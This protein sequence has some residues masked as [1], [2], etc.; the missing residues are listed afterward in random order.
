MVSISGGSKRVKGRA[1]IFFGRLG[2]CKRKSNKIFRCTRLPLWQ[3]RKILSCLTTKKNSKLFNAYFHLDSKYIIQGV[4]NSQDCGLYNGKSYRSSLGLGKFSNSCT[5][6]SN[7]IQEIFELSSTLSYYWSS[8]IPT[9]IGTWKN[10]K[11]CYV[12]RGS[13]GLEKF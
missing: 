4:W 2:E 9:F 6:A 10:I 12:Y 3:L 7:G 13:S 1:V 11:C 5:P 8:S